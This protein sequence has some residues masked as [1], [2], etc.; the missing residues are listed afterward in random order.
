MRPTA[1]HN[2]IDDI[3]RAQAILSTPNSWE[4][5]TTHK[6]EICVAD[7]CRFHD[8]MLLHRT[9]D[10]KFRIKLH[11]NFKSSEGRACAWA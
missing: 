1:G 9:V 6:S 7:V 4:L 5:E 2:H 11:I 8:D 10:D 3:E